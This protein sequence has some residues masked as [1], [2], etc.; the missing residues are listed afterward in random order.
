[1]FRKMI[2]VQCRTQ[3]FKFPLGLRAPAAACLLGPQL[4]GCL[5]E[6]LVFSWTETCFLQTSSIWPASISP[7]NNSQTRGYHR[8][9]RGMSLL[10][11][12][13][14]SKYLQEVNT[15]VSLTSYGGILT[16]SGGEYRWGLER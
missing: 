1:M 2:Q 10:G 15:C 11:C 6:C 14:E 12:S 5:L 16:H 9:P 4:K 7:C 8:I 3:Q 13:P